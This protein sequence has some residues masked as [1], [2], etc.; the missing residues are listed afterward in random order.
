MLMAERFRAIYYGWWVVFSS[1][2]VLFMGL[3]FGLYTFP[4]FYPALTESFGWSRGEVVTGGS[5]L[6]VVLGVMSPF[7]GMILDRIGAKVILTIGVMTVGVALFAFVVV[8][9]LWQFYVA[10]LLLGLGLCGVSHMPNQVLITNWFNEKRGLAIGSINAGVGIGGTVGPILV[11]YLINHYGWRAGFAG[12]GAAVVAIPLLL[13]IFVIKRCPQDIGLLPD[14]RENNDEFRTQN[15]EQIR[16]SVHHSSFI[17]HHSD[18]FRAVRTGR[19][20]LLFWAI[21]LISAMMFTISQHLVVY[22]RDKGFASQ[23][24]ASTLSLVLFMSAVG[25][26]L[27]GALSDHLNRRNVMLISFLLLTGSSLC[28]LVAPRPSLIYPFAV[29]FGLGFGGVF[30]NMPLVTAEYFG[31]RA[32]GKILG[33]IFLSFNFGGSLWP[34]AAGYLFDWLGN[35]DV[36]FLINPILGFAATGAVLWLPRSS[37]ER[38]ASNRNLVANEPFSS[39]IQEIE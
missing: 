24:A 32:L 14:G 9:S 21:F 34:I 30:S 13:V 18:L 39:A 26:L 2:I 23:Q 4:V 8:G 6:M 37:A 19:F 20:W 11:T 27:F 38:G 16:K 15:D 33:L 1:A 35:Y 25:K 22:L 10:C 7:I 3:G 29:A 36:V 17:I 12:M 28:L 5:L 31:L